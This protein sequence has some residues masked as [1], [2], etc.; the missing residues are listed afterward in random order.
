[1]QLNISDKIT[2]LIAGLLLVTMFTTAF[3]SM[4]QAALTYDELAHIPAGYSYLTQQD[5]RINPEHPPLAKSI[6]AFPLI[7]LDLNFPTD[8]PNWTQENNPP[9]WWVQFDLG[10]EFLYE[11]GNNPRQII[12]WSRF[13]MIGMLVFMG[14]FLF[15]WARELGGNKVAL[16]VLALFS[17]SPTFLAH[18]RLVNTD[19]AA[20]LGVVVA[21]YYWIKFIKN[22]SWI[23]VVKAGVAFL[24]AL[25]LK[26]SLI[27]LVPFFG[28]LAITYPLLSPGDKKK[29][30]LEYIGKGALAG[31]I[32]V[33]LIWPVYQ[34]AIAN[35][36]AERQLRDT[37]ADLQPES[38]TVPESAAV[39]MADKEPFRPWGQYARGLL[40]AVQ[41]GQF[42]NTT[43]FLG[44]MRSSS[45]FY[46]FP[47]MYAT[48]IPIAFHLLTGMVALWEIRRII[49]A[50]R[51]SEKIKRGA[52]WIKD[53]FD[54]SAFFL[55]IAIYWAAS[56]NTN[57]NLGIRH[58]MPI[59]PF[60][61]FLVVL[62]AKRMFNGSYFTRNRTIAYSL[63][64]VIFGWYGLSSLSVFPHYIPYYNALAGGTDDGYQVAVDSNYDW[65]QDFYKLVS[66]VEENNI[67]KVHLNYFG[68][69]DPEYWLGDKYIKYNPRE[70]ERPTG[71]LAVSVNELMGG[72][73]EP[74]P[75]YDQPTGYYNWL[76]EYE[77]VEILGYSIFVYYI[78]PEIQ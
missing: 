4:K 62:G 28:I 34:F 31:I 46:Y 58:L 49:R 50:S 35:Y 18:G 64:V 9:A 7:F 32:G 13:A 74:H 47:V 10:R 41:R 16:G 56:I 44:E 42:G 54:I 69:E 27:L 51:K 53:N 24:F 38:I 77:P 3:F 17:F 6:G 37:V 25:L 67:E 60:M 36:P 59:F 29:K 52:T 61:Y 72:K 20:A 43:F 73:G 22:P 76:N 21:T 2:F 11:S 55:F 45:W 15:R 5:Y 30:L 75:T 1:M 23:N 71:W 70:D 40:M 8:S 48:K 78:P 12:V 57:L 39:W 63:V 33:L 14:W 26:F 19:I 65:G 66:Y 68:G